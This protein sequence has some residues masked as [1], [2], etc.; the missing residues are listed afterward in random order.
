MATDLTPSEIEQYKEKLAELEIQLE[1]SITTGLA[2]K[3]RREKAIQD[4]RIFKKDWEYFDRI[5]RSYEKI[6]EYISGQYIAK[7]LLEKDLVEH[8]QNRGRLYQAPRSL[9]P[10]KIREMIGKG[11]SSKLRP[12]RENLVVENLDQVINV[13]LNGL[14]PHTGSTSFL[15]SDYFAGNG[16]IATNDQLTTNEWYLMGN[17]VFIQVGSGT[18]SGSNFI[19][20]I[21]GRL[22]VPNADA[23]V[24]NG[25]SVT[26]FNGFTDTERSSRDT[27]VSSQQAFFN[28]LA[29]GIENYVDRWKPLLEKQVAQQEKLVVDDPSFNLSLKT[30]N[31]DIIN[32]LDTYIS[33]SYPLQDGSSNIDGLLSNSSTRVGNISSLVSELETAKSAY[34]SDRIQITIARANR[35]SG[36]LFRK[37]FTEELTNSYPETGDSNI[38]SQINRISRRLEDIETE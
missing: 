1:A 37:F 8:V 5:I 35:Q 4:E 36:T 14:G 12:E 17:R 23:N 34:Y 21:I 25:S 31:E 22:S 28:S 2:A 3:E 32:F 30:D 19:H 29:S 13:L 24:G 16:S 27:N 11:L 10:K 33:N 26:F 7:P 38:R 15:V 18:P 20:P 9:D 6:I